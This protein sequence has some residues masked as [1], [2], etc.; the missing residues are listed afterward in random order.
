METK[1]IQR[2]PVVVIMGHIDHG[3][4]TLLDYIRKTN[5]T[6]KEAGGI[7]QHLSAYMVEHKDEHG[8]MKAITFLDTPG[9]EAFSSMR[10]RGA[11]TADIAILVVSAEDSVKAQTLEAYATIVE[12][13]IPYIVAI[14][15]IDK[16]GAN[17]E[18]TKLDL[19]EKGIYLEGYGG[20]IPFVEI[21]AKEGT[22]IKELLDLILLVADLHELTADTT[23][24]AEGIIIESNL[25]TKRGISA[26]LLIKEGTLK[27]GMYLVA[28]NTLVGTRIME[29][30]LGKNIDTAGISVPVKVV[31][32]DTPPR[33][34]SHF[35]SFLNKKE[36][37]K[38]IALWNELNTKNNSQNEVYA[39]DTKV[40]PIIIKTDV[41]GTGEAVEKEIKKLELPNVV[42]KV[43]ARLV[44]PISENDIKLASSDKEA[45]IVGFNVAIDPR[46]RELNENAHVFVETFTVIYKISDFLKEEI[47]KRRPR[48]M[49][50]EVTGTLKILRT[51]SKT[52]ERQVLG[53][54]VIDGILISG[55]EVRIM[56]REFEIGR[57]K[58]IELQH[59]KLKVKNLE[60]DND[61][62]VLVESKTE[63]ATGDT[64][65]CFNEVEK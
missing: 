19:A 37:E 48:T 40:I 63:I 45:I 18:K 58:I 5:V 46:A 14:N 1:K 60:K 28:E 31:G 13:N 24:P 55:R 11:Q 8:N 59:N 41:S 57:A 51:F 16:A 34:G 29:N 49:T 42:F 53:G 62:G 44:G 52:K 54:K 21:S 2:P 50:L 32:F 38:E 39:T 23:K 47:E 61:C 43:L 4:S 35:K 36:A 7:T 26:T 65:E 20:D 27:K 56:R 6:E 3:K 17:I 10:E 64:L 9:H 22:Q 15:K 30:F 12:S 25:D 33:V